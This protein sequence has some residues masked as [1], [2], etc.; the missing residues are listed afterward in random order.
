MP[1]YTLHSKEVKWKPSH[2]SLF[3]LRAINKIILLTLINLAFLT[4]FNYVVMSS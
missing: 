2:I 1:T 4:F 3:L